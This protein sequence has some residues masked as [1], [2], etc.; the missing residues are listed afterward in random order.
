MGRG[1]YEGKGVV[2]EGQVQRDEGR[3]GPSETRGKVMGREEDENERGS[4]SNNVGW[5]SCG[6]DEYKLGRRKETGIVGE[7]KKTREENHTLT[8]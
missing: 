2:E 8:L 7:K 3:G 1:N 5:M 4:W 6:E